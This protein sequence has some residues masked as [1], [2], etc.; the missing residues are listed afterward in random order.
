MNSVLIVGCVPFPYGGAASSRMRS[1]ALGL[2]E[3]GITVEVLAY[4]SDSHT[5]NPENEYQGRWRN[6]PICTFSFRKDGN[7]KKTRWLRLRWRENEAILKRVEKYCQEARVQTLLFYN[8]EPGLAIKIA[9]I[10]RRWNVAF[11]QQYAELHSRADIGRGVPLAH[12]LRERLHIKIVP[13]L[14][15]GAVVISRLLQA[16]CAISPKYPVLKVPALINT[17]PYQL[18]PRF[19][20]TPFTFTYLGAG[21]RRDC[22]PELL[23]GFRLL[24]L[25]HP[26]CNLQLLGLGANVEIRL[27]KICE[28]YNLSESVRVQTWCSEAELQS[29]IAKTHAFILLRTDDISS[30]ACF[31]TRLPEFLLHGRPLL[32]SGVGDAANLLCPD[33]EYV[34]VRSLAQD[35]LVGAMASLIRDP[36]RWQSIATEGAKAAQREFGFERWGRELAFFIE[37][38]KFSMRGKRVHSPKNNG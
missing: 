33:R 27:K 16:R 23:A 37:Q 5:K 11:I 36:V 2:L 20:G 15:T 6:V 34:P 30:W 4:S 21:A 3:A 35:D 7:A 9:L 22:L 24:R 38:L 29:A 10:C 8:Q 17:E 1:L 31:P 14:A 19:T 32:M 13:H 12:F 26:E 28:S 18:C 25:L